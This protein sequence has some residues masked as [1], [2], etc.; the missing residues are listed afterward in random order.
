MEIYV[1]YNLIFYVLAFLSCVFFL[2]L[3]FICYKL[4]KK[5]SE[6]IISYL[7]MLTLFSIFFIILFAPIISAKMGY[8]KKINVEDWQKKVSIK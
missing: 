2:I 5:R 8:A 4:M 6:K 3:G 7:F 1:Q